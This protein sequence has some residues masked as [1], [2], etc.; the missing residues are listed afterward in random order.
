[1][2]NNNEDKSL[3]TLELT[4][5]EINL[6]YKE[7]SEMKIEE[8][9]NDGN[10]L[11]G[12]ETRLFPSELTDKLPIS[13]SE[14]VPEF[15]NQI[16]TMSNIPPHVDRESLEIHL[17]ELAPDSEIQITSP[18][19]DKSFYRLAWLKLADNSV[20]KVSELVP[21]LESLSS[22]EGA[23]V[24]FGISSS[25]FRR[26]KVTNYIEGSEE[27]LYNLAIKLIKSLEENF[28]ESL[29]IKSENDSFTQ[30][31][32][33]AVI[34]LRNV[35]KFCFY[36]VASFS[37]Q[38]EMLIKCSDLHLRKVSEGETTKHDQHRLIE[39]LSAL[40]NFIQNLSEI[41]KDLSVDLDEI[42]SESSVKKVEEGKFRCNHC[43][44]AF[45]GSEF[46]LKHLT[47][48]HED[49]IKQSQDEIADFNRLLANAPLWLFPTT[50]IPRYTKIRSKYANNYNQSSS[51]R[52]SYSSSKSSVSVS[53]NSRQYMD[54]DA[55]IN[56][57]S[58]TEISYDL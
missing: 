5:S 55:N 26:F 27:E 12:C 49:V 53:K 52:D 54:W 42:L 58:S 38:Q 1:M 41:S 32:D 4:T 29:M 48:K 43:A 10:F 50:M 51:S 30:L 57:N 23:K 25:N 8:S 18:N 44:K 34:Y 19:A 56:S 46:V 6:E 40:I 9:S 2:I 7:S 17:K 35:H 33:K 45:K 36:C 20:E 15:L 11:T 47:L 16:I 22:I 14:L 37:C 28:D 3:D 13:I 24:Y 31:L 39:K 21:K